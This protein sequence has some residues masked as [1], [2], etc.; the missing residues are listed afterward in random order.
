MNPPSRKPAARPQPTPIPTPKIKKLR[1]TLKAWYEKNGR[2]LPWRRRVSD[3][4]AVM[5]SEFMLQQTQVA[6]VLPYY[7]RF[8]NEFPTMESL[9][10]ADEITVRA[11]WSG[12]GYYRRATNL[13][14]A[15]RSIITDHH[16]TLPKD[17]N[18]LRALP[19]VG[20]Y[21]AAALGSIVHDLPRGVVDGNVIRVL[22]RLTAFAEPVSTTAA[23]NS[24]QDLA[25]QLVDPENPGD[26]NQAIMELGA[27]VCAT[28]NP[29][30]DVCPW[31]T[32]CEANHQGTPQNF[33]RKAPARETIQVERAVGI[34][35]NGAALLLT[36]RDDPLLL[37]GTWELPGL[38]VAEGKD[39]K[40]TLA[41]HLEVTLGT[42]LRVGAELARVRHSITHRRLLIRGFEVQTTRRPRSKSGTRKWIELDDL[43]DYPVSSMTTK[44]FRKLQPTADD[45]P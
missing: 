1:T 32:A 21:T 3:P 20:D 38:E 6:T 9:A 13:Q 29:S 43:R 15:A 14:A 41:E 34:L 23:K 45:T 40:A 4:Y 31:T 42:N 18:A 8:L 33:P 12:L 5:V 30:C 24:L 36:F 7:E 39:P 16:G 37:G 27:T 28:R 44:M 26:W 22:T 35:R 17:L 19:G 2:D 11:A 10:A 25:D